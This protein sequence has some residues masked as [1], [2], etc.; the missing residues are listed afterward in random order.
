MSASARH[1]DRMEAPSARGTGIIP[2]GAR[3]LHVPI[4]PY[5]Q[6]DESRDITGRFG[7][8]Q[9]LAGLGAGAWHG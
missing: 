4:L 8:V 9:I 3:E 7:S 6:D 1:W 5:A 2:S